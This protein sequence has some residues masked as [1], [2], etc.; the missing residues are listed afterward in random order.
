MSHSVK[1]A[2]KD[3]VWLGGYHVCWDVLVGVFGITVMN[4]RLR[5]SAIRRR[6]ISMMSSF[7]VVPASIS[8]HLVLR[9]LRSKAAC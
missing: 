9:W 2:F 6:S 3:Q 1:V 5:S 4:I 7:V 8:D